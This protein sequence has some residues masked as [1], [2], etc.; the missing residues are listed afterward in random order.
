MKNFL[1]AFLLLFSLS[2]VMS[3]CED[4][5]F[6]EALQQGQSQNADG[7]NDDDDDGINDDDDDDDDDN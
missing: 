7:V 2:G 6:G 4:E 3:S 5:S 1:L